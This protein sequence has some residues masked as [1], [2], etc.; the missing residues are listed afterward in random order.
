MPS[1]S[2]SIFI[3]VPNKADKQ[4]RQT[5]FLLNVHAEKHSHHPTHTA[6]NITA[7]NRQANNRIDIQLTRNFCDCIAMN[8]KPHWY[9]LQRF[10]TICPDYIFLSACECRLTAPQARKFLLGWLSWTPINPRRKLRSPPKIANVN[11]WNFD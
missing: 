7:T 6:A 9:Y 1:A 10:F 2:S 3:S 11:R 4:T 5:T 8:I